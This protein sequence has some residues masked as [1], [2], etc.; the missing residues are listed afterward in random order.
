MGLDGH[1]QQASDVF[2]SEVLMKYPLNTVAYGVGVD[3]HLR[4]GRTLEAR[5]LYHQLKNNGLEPNVQTFNMILFSSFEV[6]DLQ[7]VKQLLKDMID[8]RIK[9]SDRNFFNLCKFQCNWN[10]LTEMGD[11]GLLSS[12]ALHAE[13]VKANYKHCAEVDTECNSSSEDIS[14]VAVSVC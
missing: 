10:L 11:L 8:S 2:I 13:S 5:T 4:S 12:K 1:Y 3:A 9:L 6:K 7:M 14:D